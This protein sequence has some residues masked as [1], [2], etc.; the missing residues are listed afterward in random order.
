MNLSKLILSIS[1]LSA[2]TMQSMQTST[3]GFLA[4]SSSS[5]SDDLSP[6]LCIGSSTGTTIA[7]IVSDILCGT[8]G[9][10]ACGAVAGG[11]LVGYIGKKTVP[12]CLTACP[13]C[14]ENCLT[15]T[16]K[17][18]SLTVRQPL[19]QEPKL[20]LQDTFPQANNP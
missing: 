19:I 3:I 8:K 15:K 9:M 14:H 2:N 12:T 16:H 5:S 13:N 11:G 17:K 4:T 7:I 1:I 10:I 18:Q 6:A 20:S